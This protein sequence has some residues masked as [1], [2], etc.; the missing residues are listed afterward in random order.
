MPRAGFA[1]SIL[2]WIVAT[3]PAA[4]TDLVDLL[5]E[6]T[7]PIN[8]AGI[9]TPFDCA[10][11]NLCGADALQANVLDLASFELQPISDFTASVVNDRI[12]PLSS[13]VSGFTYEYNED[14]DVYE[15]S[16]STFGPLFSE[17]AQ[18][19]GRGRFLVGVSHSVLEFDEFNGTGLDNINLAELA[20]NAVVGSSAAGGLSIGNVLGSQG[21][22]A[23]DL[24][25]DIEIDEAVSTFYF[26]YGLTDRIDLGVVVPLVRIEMDVTARPIVP[27]GTIDLPA[28][29]DLSVLSTEDCLVNPENFRVQRDSATHSGVGDVVLRA[30]WHFLAGRTNAS[31]FLSS[32]LPT[33]DEDNLAGFGDPTFTPGIVLSR[34]FETA[35]GGIALNAFAGYEIRTDDTDKDEIEWGVGASFQPFGRASL[36]LDVLG[37]KE[38]QSDEEFNVVDLSVGLKLMLRE[39]VLLDFNYIAPL[40][41]EGLRATDGI[42]SAQVEWVFGD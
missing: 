1:L 26:T 31:L 30:K 33:G 15:R 10:F 27:G 18:T 21:S 24:N 19:I 39:G 14:L 2:F 42:I 8:G 40:N 3:P 35:F 11:N 34:D 29:E 41:D 25:Y 4:A 20:R 17:R 12:V 38:T 7:A 37:T 32:T 5:R 23:I 16:T 6:V 28:C 9:S 13:S 22:R 36:N